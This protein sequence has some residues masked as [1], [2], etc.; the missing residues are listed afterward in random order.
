MLWR[1]STSCTA[2]SRAASRLGQRSP[3]RPDF[4]RPGRR[5]HPGYQ[6]GELGPRLRPD[7]AHA[8]INDTGAL[9]GFDAG[10]DGWGPPPPKDAAP[11]KKETYD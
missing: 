6:Q 4:D 9:V 3:R 8:V 2:S 7:A 5:P 10:S 1:A 11:A